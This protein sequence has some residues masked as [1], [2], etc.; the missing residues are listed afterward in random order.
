MSLELFY[1]GT[2]KGLPAAQVCPPLRDLLF[3][4]LIGERRH[5]VHACIHIPRHVPAT[6]FPLRPR[7][8]ELR[9]AFFRDPVVLAP[10]AV[11]RRG[12]LR[13]DMALTLEAVQHG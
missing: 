2:V 11:L 5:T 7:R 8:G 3:E 4:R 13:R 12:P 6:A 10:A 1:V 9:P